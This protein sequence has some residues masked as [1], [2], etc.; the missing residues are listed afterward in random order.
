MR[1]TNPF[2]GKY[3]RLSTSEAGKQEFKF[4]ALNGPSYYSYEIPD[5]KYASSFT[6]ADYLVSDVNAEPSKPSCGYLLCSYL[7]TL[8]CYVLFL[9]TLP[10]SLIFTLKMI[11]SYEKLVVFRLG[12]YLDTKSSGYTIVLPC[13]DCWEKVDMR[14]KA[15]S[16]PPQKIITIDN[17]VIEIG[18]EIYH[19]VVDPLMSIKNIQD[20]NHST[21]ILCQTS[22]QKHVGKQKLS[23]IE[24]AHYSIN[25]E[26]RKDV[27][28]ITKKWGV[29]VT[30]VELSS[31]K[32][33]SKP[34]DAVEDP[35]NP[36]SLL[37]PVLFPPGSCNPP[38]EQLKHFF[39]LNVD[40]TRPAKSDE[41]I[42]MENSQ[43]SNHL[44]HISEEEINVYINNFIDN[45]RMQLEHIL[46]KD[47][48]LIYKFILIP[49]GPS[50]KQDDKMIFFL[51]LKNA[52]GSVG[53]GYP[54]DEEADVTL[55]LNRRT[56]KELLSKELSPFNAFI[57]GK[58]IIS[59]DLRGGMK[60]GNLI[61]QLKR[62]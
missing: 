5:K 12:R 4:N 6:Y 59:G 33:Y 9:L 26:L 27:N 25:E 23:E 28:Q 1:Y 7:S 10:F 15:F 20:L 39:G 31:F 24:T 21:R 17:A 58:L 54:Y 62:I 42:L 47:F 37:G 13:I 11:K 8:V 34:C 14:M 2:Q 16:V 61:E 19:N 48:Q 55:T 32:L 40:D 57:D 30:K 3:V 18:A 53:K 35:S 60:L 36:L 43:E 38:V 44:E 51:D 46:I 50:L 41:A 49:D 52:G 29:E 45:V 22:L 56:L